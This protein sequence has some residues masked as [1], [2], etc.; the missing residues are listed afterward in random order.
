[1]H[2]ADAIIRVQRR[3]LE[4]WKR[5]DT[6][7]VCHSAG[8]DTVLSVEVQP[9]RKYAYYTEGCRAA[10]VDDVPS[11]LAQQR[12][13]LECESNEHI[14][15]DHTRAQ[16]FDII[17]EY[18]RGL[19]GNIAGFLGIERRYYSRTTAVLYRSRALGDQILD[20]GN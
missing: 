13:E 1:M 15:L 9:K 10:T 8:V 14:E 16:F 12:R 20:L 7:F 11:S 5:G 4:F 6:R 17:R 18:H 19:A 3:W 2:N